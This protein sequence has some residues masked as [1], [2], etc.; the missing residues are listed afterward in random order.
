MKK[1]ITFGVFDCFHYGHLKLLERCKELGDF[2]IVAVQDDTN[3]I[4]NKPGV[5]LFYNENQRLEMV[6]SLK[7]VNQ[8]ILY[9]QID[10]TLKKVDFD[11]LVVGPDQTNEHFK[12]AFNYCTNQNKNIVVLPRTP[13]ISSSLIRAKD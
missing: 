4:K 10:E 6:K 11:V 9:S 3:T 12:K 2:L 13:G 8:V 5:H 1:I 7:F